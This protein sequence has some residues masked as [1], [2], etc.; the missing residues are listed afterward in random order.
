MNKNDYLTKKGLLPP[1]EL[2]NTFMYLF[3]SD[4]NGVSEISKRQVWGIR[5]S[6]TRFR[7]DENGNRSEGI[8]VMEYRLHGYGPSTKGEYPSTVNIVMGEDSGEDHGYASGFGDLWGGATFY[9]LSLDKLIIKRMEEFK[10]ITEK[11]GKNTGEEEYLT[12]MG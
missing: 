5:K 7:Y 2:E 4:R 12:T 10:R 11:Y 3:N 8:D 1:K 9:S 6:S